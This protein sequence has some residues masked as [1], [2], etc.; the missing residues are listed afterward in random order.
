M[1]SDRDLRHPGAAIAD[2]QI[3]E[4]TTDSTNGY[5]QALSK[6]ASTTA[7]A[8]AA[9][10]RSEALVHPKKPVTKEGTPAQGD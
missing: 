4:V 9:A 7:S 1:Y 10:R 3:A 5:V 2:M 6:D 8:A